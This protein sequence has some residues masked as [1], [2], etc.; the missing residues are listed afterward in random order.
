MKLT[1]AQERAQAKLTQ[2]WQC[3]YELGESLPTLEGLVARKAAVMKRDALGMMY[4]PRTAV[5]F[6]LPNAEVSGR[7]SEAG[8]GRA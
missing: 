2:E 6:K 7:A 1:K 4:S 8:D 5:H 3:A